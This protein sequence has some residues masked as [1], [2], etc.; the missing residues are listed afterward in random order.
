MTFSGVESLGPMEP[1][2][3]VLLEFCDEGPELRRKKTFSAVGF[4]H[5]RMPFLSMQQR[6]CEESN[7]KERARSG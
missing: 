1:T 5:D 3:L 2:R 4:G 7:G 6:A